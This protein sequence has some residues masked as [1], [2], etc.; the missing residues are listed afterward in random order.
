VEAA[1][2]YKYFVE[3]IPKNVDSA[4]FLNSDKLTTEP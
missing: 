1:N 2:L 4:V 3:I